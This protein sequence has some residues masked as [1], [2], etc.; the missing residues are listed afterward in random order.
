MTER[1]PIAPGTIFEAIDDTRLFA[2]WF[3]DR[4]T[5]AAWFAFLAALFGLSM[6]K[7]QLATYRE[8]TGRTD[9]PTAPA[10]EAWLICGRRAGKSFVLA[11]VAVF[12]AC[13]RSYAEHLQPGERATVLIVAR[14]RRQARVI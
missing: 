7:Q 6:T 1:R 12:L 2:R 11:L 9:P 4:R 3:R 5:W 13:F 8:C 14:D 10:D